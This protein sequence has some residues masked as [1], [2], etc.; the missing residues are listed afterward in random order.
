M[1]PALQLARVLPLALTPN[2]R[3]TH[4]PAH[5]HMQLVPPTHTPQH[6]FHHFHR[7][8]RPA[9]VIPKENNFQQ[10]GQRYRSWDPARQDRFVQRVSDVLNDPR[11]T[12]VGSARARH[13]A[14]PQIGRFG[15][16]GSDCEK[17]CPRRCCHPRP[18]L[19]MPRLYGRGACPPSARPTQRTLLPR[20]LQE[21]RRVWLGML[22]Q[23]D[24]G[25]GQ[26]VAAKL[27]AAGS[28]L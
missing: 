24:A 6:N 21:I 12:Q 25:M 7:F 11:C 4:K 26:K 10:P 16:V 18:L 8:T 9:A 27:Q 1:L 2:R 20:L 14:Q 28:A 15:D 23:C 3:N 22:S 17:G 13:A 5:K 19:S